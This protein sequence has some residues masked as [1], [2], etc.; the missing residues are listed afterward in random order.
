MKKIII[1]FTLIALL[2]TACG[3]TQ[4][5]P[6]QTS[7]NL[8]AVTQ[9]ALGTLKLKGTDQV[10]TND[11]AQ[12]LLPLWQIYQELSNSDNA[13]QTEFE[14]VTE[15]IQETMTTEQMQAITDMKL[16]QQDVSEV[17]QAQKITSSSNDSNNADS[18]PSNSGM[19]A[20]GPPDAGG[21]PFGG[22][23]GGPSTDGGIGGLVGAGGAGSGTSAGQNQETGT[24]P[25]LGSSAGVPTVLIDAVI[26][27]LGQMVSS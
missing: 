25:S 15:Q 11:Q 3:N 9:L 19:P 22:G 14:A 12:E 6:A 23:M 5:G 8:P 13:A 21:A 26:E 7:D 10:V 20:G 24:G 2:L 27:Y 18:A 16:T 1:L 17:V 4:V